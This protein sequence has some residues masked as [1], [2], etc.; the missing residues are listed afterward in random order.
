MMDKVDIALMLAGIWI[1]LL[2]TIIVSAY[3]DHKYDQRINELERQACAWEYYEDGSAA[4]QRDDS[5]RYACLA[6]K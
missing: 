3:N 2:A 1:I 5:I 6:D 4:P